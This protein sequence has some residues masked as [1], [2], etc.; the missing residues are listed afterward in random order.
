M[1]TLLGYAGWGAGQLEA[2]IVENVWLL[3]PVDRKILFETPFSERPARAANAMGIDLNLIV[4][5]AGHG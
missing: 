4:P 1:L 5:S 3:T 2:E